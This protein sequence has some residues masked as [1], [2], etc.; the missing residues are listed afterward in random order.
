MERAKFFAR[1]ANER[2]QGI[3]PKHLADRD[4][5]ADLRFEVVVL[6]LP[7]ILTSIAVQRL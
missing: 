2:L 1:L 3:S 5:A 7:S 4:T 6:K